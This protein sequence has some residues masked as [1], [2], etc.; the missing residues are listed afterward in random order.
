MSTCINKRHSNSAAP[1]AR[2]LLDD[3][4]YL[5]PQQVTGSPAWCNRQGTAG[6]VAGKL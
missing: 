1:A 2:P 5:Q 3:A 6:D 4:G